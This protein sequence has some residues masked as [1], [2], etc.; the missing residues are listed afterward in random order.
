[1]YP[2]M[3]NLPLHYLLQID[4]PSI[5]LDILIIFL[6]IFI[7]LV[8]FVWEPVP[9]DITAIALIV[10]LV[11]L[12]PWTK[13]TPELAVSGFSNTATI[14]VLAMFVLSEGIRR[15]G[16]VK[17][18]GDKIVEATKGSPRK[19]LGAVMGISGFSAGFINNTPVVAVM[20]PMIHN[21]A[22]SENTSP[23][24]LLMPVSFTAMMG[25]MLTLIGTS[26]NILAS[27]VSNRLLDRPFGMFEFTH[28]GLI[29]LITG[30][31]YMLF[32]GARFI[33]SRIQPRAQLT[34]EFELA[35]YLTEVVVTEDSP[36]I[37]AT[38]S[39]TMEELDI[40]FDIVQIIR[41]G[42]VFMEPLD[43]KELREGDILVVRTDRDSLMELI[44]AENLDLLP[45][46]KLSDEDLD[47]D[48]ESPHLVEVVIAPETNLIGETLDSLSF[49]QRYDATVL[50][51]RRGGKLK[52]E[53][54]DNIP[55][56]PG[57]TMLIQ[58]TGD[59]VDRLTQHR[60]F[61]VAESFETTV[62]RKKK[63]P[64]AIAIIAGVV[65][66][67]ALGI[68]PIMVTA[69]AGVVA[70][71]ATGCVK[72]TEVYDSIGW[73]VIFLLAGVIPLGISLERTGASAWL[74]S[75]IV[76]ISVHLPEIVVLGLFYILTALITQVI[77]NNAS[78]VLM[79]P[80]AIDAA[81]QLGANKFAFVLA[82]TFA[83]STALLTPI[84]YQ[85][86]LMV[87]GPGGYRFSDFFKVG[88]PLQVILTI[89][90]TLG[91]A[92]FWG[93]G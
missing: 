46:V 81:G 7:A 29:V 17:I 84:G 43:R 28:L 26:S 44:Q 82:V 78:I 73:N 15:T 6:I 33:P 57:D 87:Y 32:I 55:L 2:L 89:V 92:F 65:A 59:T 49:R 27:D 52:R 83:A 71:V 74:A 16:I 80:V 66:L 53:R 37:G 30:F 85:T 41:A 86:N 9:I 56:K 23:S 12:E 24:K 88:A 34:D 47:P 90:T 70:M 1:M 75:Q 69:L 62:Y 40:D 93:L 19:Q 91:I 14:T 5:T 20:I 50:A 11:V 21:I 72:P 25:G 35:E 39:D 79:V 18:I 45:E 38:I 63:I 77:S 51:I 31:L 22:E 54:L 36:M 60:A 68:Y 48:E 42:E 76:D 61:I 64:L 3:D 8:L 13:I 67:A 10:T 4:T 58:A